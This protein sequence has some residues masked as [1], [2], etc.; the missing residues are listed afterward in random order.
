MYAGRIVETGPAETITRSPAHPYTRGLLA[1]AKHLEEGRV[2]A[3]IPGQ[4]HS[5]TNHPPGCRFHLRCPE[6]LPSCATHEPPE[7][8]LSP[9]H[10]VRCW[11]YATFENDH[12]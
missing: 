3:T 5:P 4:V 9:G 1:A 2:R 11:L 7:T 10:A 12:R 6:A 8:A